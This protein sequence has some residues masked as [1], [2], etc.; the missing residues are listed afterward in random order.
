MNCHCPT[1]PAMKLHRVHLWRTVYRHL[2]FSRWAFSCS[3]CP[4]QE[5]IKPSWR[6]CLFEPLT[7]VEHN[8]ANIKTAFDFLSTLVLRDQSKWRAN[9]NE[10]GERYIMLIPRFVLKVIDNEKKKFACH[11]MIA[12]ENKLCWWSLECVNNQGIYP[13]LRQSSVSFTYLFKFT[14]FC[15]VDVWVLKKEFCL[16]K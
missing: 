1:P 13:K 2:I 15:F 7:K 10:H 16:R 9:K 6:K 5:K 3:Y 4:F 8:F 12:L 11:E 14:Y